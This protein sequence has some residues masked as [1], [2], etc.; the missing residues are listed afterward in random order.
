MLAFSAQHG[1]KPMIETFPMAEANAALD[2]TRQGKARF[3]AVLVARSAYRW[4]GVAEVAAS[5]ICDQLHSFDNLVAGHC[6]QF[7]IRAA[8]LSL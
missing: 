7:C 3:R 8:Y 1:I 5:P 4:G 6:L 2:H